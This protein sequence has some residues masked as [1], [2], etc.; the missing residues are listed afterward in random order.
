MVQAGEALCPQARAAAHEAEEGLLCLPENQPGRG[1]V[2]LHQTQETPS[3]S[4]TQS[5]AAKF[6]GLRRPGLRGTSAVTQAVLPWGRARAGRWGVVSKP[7]SA[8]E[9]GGAWEHV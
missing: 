6:R 7:E 1:N 2:C 4:S 5:M 8:W 3:R 9:R